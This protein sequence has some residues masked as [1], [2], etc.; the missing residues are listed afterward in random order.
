MHRREGNSCGVSW[1]GHAK[2]S[3]RIVSGLSFQNSARLEDRVVLVQDPI[4]ARC[5]LDLGFVCR[6]DLTEAEPSVVTPGSVK[7]LVAFD[8]EGGKKGVGLVVELTIAEFSQSRA[9]S[10]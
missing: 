6:L 8:A 9:A 5:R 2:V 10:P 3:E 7:Q 1:N 4:V